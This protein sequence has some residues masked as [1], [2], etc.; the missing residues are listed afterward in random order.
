MSRSIAIA[1][2]RM[3]ACRWGVG[4]PVRGAQGFPRLDLR[5]QEVLAASSAM[6][7]AIRPSQVDRL[8]VE[9]VERISRV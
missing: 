8:S 1:R 2:Y 6:P 5:K 3:P 4:A 9:F 7:S